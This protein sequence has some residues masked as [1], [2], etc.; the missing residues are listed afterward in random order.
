MKKNWIKIAAIYIGTVIGAG[1]A[2]GREIVD[3]F[4]IYGRKGIWGVYIAGFLFSIIGSLL[5]IRIYDEKIENFSQLLE[6]IFDEKIGFIVDTLVLLSLY[7]GFA[8]MVAGSG[9]IFKEQLDKPFSIGVMTMLIACFLVFLFDLEGLS[10]IN[11]VLVPILIVGILFNSYYIASQDG[12]NFANIEGVGISI[13]GNFLTSA[14]I[15]FGSNCLIIIV[16]FSSL[17]P[18]IKN[19]K[20]A[21]AGGIVGGGILYIL[22]LAILNSI[23][24]FYNDVLYVDIPM[25]TISNHIGKTYGMTYS[26]ILW[27]AM[28][29]TAL[30]NGFGFIR[31]LSKKENNL[32]VALGLSLSTIPLAR[33]GFSKLV[34]IL[35]PI[36][37]LIGFTMMVMILTIKNRS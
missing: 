11:T 1:F 26:I 29:T 8:I 15:Y 21:L 18:L 20:T 9:A 4:A 23:L 24:L 2:S 22:G 3:F 34:G 19:R 14:I 33:L 10:F 13:K 6:R 7:T 25:L 17:L 37:G 27:V 28:F 36:F 31:R 30:A 32:L 16:V 35:Y 5:L 12:Y